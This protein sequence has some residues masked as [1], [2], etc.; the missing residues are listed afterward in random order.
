LFKVIKLDQA[1]HSQYV[2]QIGSFWGPCDRHKEMAWNFDNFWSVGQ[3]LCCL[4]A[5]NF[6]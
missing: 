4:M 5:R 1:N 3:R 6:K 2:G